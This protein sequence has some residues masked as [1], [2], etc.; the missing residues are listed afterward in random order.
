MAISG[1]AIIPFLIGYAMKMNINGGVVVLFACI[2][3]ILL[4]ALFLKEKRAS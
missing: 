2:I 1:G 4:I 3:Y